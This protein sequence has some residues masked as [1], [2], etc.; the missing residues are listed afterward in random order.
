MQIH[1]YP[2]WPLR[3]AHV[4]VEGLRTEHANHGTICLW[5]EDDPAQILGR[6]LDALWARLDGWA[7]TAQQGFGPED[8][9]LDAYMLFEDTNDYQVELPFG[10]LVRQGSTG[11][12]AELVGKKRGQRTL[13]MEQT[14]RGERPAE[15]N[16]DSPPLRGVFYLNR[17]IVAP[18][19]NLEQ[20]RTSLTRK[21]RKDL[22]RGLGARTPVGLAEPSGGYDF[23][24]LAWRRFGLEH[25]AVVVGFENQGESLRA[26][27]M[28]ATPNDVAALKR[29]AGPDADL[30]ASK[31]VLIAGAG[32]VGG[33]VAVALASSGIGT[34]HLYD[35]DYLKTGN[36]VRHVSPKAFV[37]YKKTHGVALVIADHAPW[38]KVEQHRLLPHGPT[39]L[40]DQIAGMDLVVD[41]TGIFSIA[42]A[43][44]E[45]CRRGNVPLI[46]GALF[47]QGAMART[48]RQAAGDTLIAARSADSAYVNLP[49]EDATSPTTGFLELGCTA[50]IN[51]A[52]PI[53]VM[54]VAADVSDACI[55]FLSGRR[56]RPDERIT[57]FRPLQQPFDR[58]GTFEARCP[59]AGT[60]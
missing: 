51:N 9:A 7:E 36:V 52:P 23:I 33:H 15:G 3:Y 26:S 28:A 19:R 48:Q 43:L 30:L 22:D 56:N 17:R 54:S 58:T 31:K 41:C 27:A 59:E 40:A 45:T 34:L 53:A 24:V 5:A 39:D 25:D 37:G 50:L 20:V 44:A 14:K 60:P 1:M 32:S 35:D 4:V 8:R 2:G 46:T 29:R 18:P 55:D 49:P 10:D 57:V 42:A 12:R 6:D 16:D 47:H 13:L 11:Y 21:Q 38:T